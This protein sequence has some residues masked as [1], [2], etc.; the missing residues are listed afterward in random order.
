[1]KQLI[2][3]DPVDWLSDR[4]N[5]HVRFGLNVA[6]SEGQQRNKDATLQMLTQARFNFAPD[7]IFPQAVIVSP[8]AALSIQ[9]K[10]RADVGFGYRVSTGAGPVADRLYAV[11]EPDAKGFRTSTLR[12]FQA[13]QHLITVDRLADKIN[14][15]RDVQQLLPLWSCDISSWAVRQ[16]ME[17]ISSGV[18]NAQNPRFARRPPLPAARIWHAADALDDGGVATLQATAGVGTAVRAGVIWADGAA[19]QQ[20]ERI[21][22]QIE[23]D[24]V[25][26]RIGL[27]QVHFFVLEPN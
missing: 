5:L 2:S 11:D 4:D 23:D 8:G 24:P 13:D 27:M 21:E 18:F 3:G 26:Q 20:F 15:S 12:R 14:A 19:E 22:V 25:S 17:P 7:R 6:D 1:M 16:F 10:S 9:V